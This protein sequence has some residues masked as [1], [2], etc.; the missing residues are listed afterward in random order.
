MSGTPDAVRRLLDDA[1]PE[2]ASWTG[3]PT[4]EDIKELPNAPAVYLLVDEHGAVIQLATTQQLRRLLRSRLVEIDPSAVS[5]R[6]DIAAIARGVRY[7]TVYSAFENRWWYYRLAREM[8]PKEY[9]RLISFGPTWFLNLDE[10]AHV[11]EISVTNRVWNA[12][13]V[14]TGP[15][16]T[17][18]TCQHALDGLREMFDL[19]R[20]P[21]QVRKAPDGQAC[22]YA[23]MGRCDA[24]CD[25]R[26]PLEP[27]VERCRRAWAFACGAIEP[28][29]HDAEIRMREAASIEAF[30]KAGQIKRNL[31]FAQQWRER[32]GNTVAP[33][34]A[35]NAFLA[36][37]VSR[38]RSWKL[39]LFR[40][41]TLVDG[42]IAQDRSLVKKAT[43][44]LTD[45]LKEPVPATPEVVR[46]EQSWLMFGLMFSKEGDQSLWV[47]G[48]L[49]TVP[50]DFAD[51]LEAALR[52]R[53]GESD[54][55]AADAAPE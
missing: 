45:R 32:W 18:S 42:P 19:C 48:P 7:R 21:E 5:G 10:A 44:W 16:P 31:V 28:W 4:R 33:V 38:R 27:Y 22:A 15:W 24:P 53:R 29:M 34:E 20:Y 46:M 17:R 40:A 30:E 43:K 50:S 2:S 25:G 47:R 36:M 41:G 39:Y 54:T 3:R 49:E 11:P 23:E 51:T 9:R 13:G 12:P 1:L 14:F 8:Y 35:Q 55:S 26:V 52:S 6:T 37:P